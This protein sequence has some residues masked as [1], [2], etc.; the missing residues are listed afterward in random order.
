VCCG[1]GIRTPQDVKEIG[2]IEG[3]E[4][5]FIGAALLEVLS[6]GIYP[7]EKYVRKILAVARNVKKGKQT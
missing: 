6:K 4:G 7:F 2:S 5:I 1:Y 3:C